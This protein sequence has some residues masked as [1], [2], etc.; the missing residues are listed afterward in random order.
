MIRNT[1]LFNKSQKNFVKIQKFFS[2]NYYSSQFWIDPF[3]SP[4]RMFNTIQTN[5]E[6][7]IDLSFL[8][9]PS[10][11]AM[12]K[13]MK[14]YGKKKELKTMIE[15]YKEMIKQKKEINEDTIEIL[16][17]YLGTKIKGNEKEFKKL[18]VDIPE[19]K[20]RNFSEK[21]NNQLIFIFHR[22]NDYEKIIEKFDEMVLKKQHKTERTYL[23]L[24]LDFIEKNDDTQL[25][26]LEEELLNEIN[27]LRLKNENENENISKQM[28]ELI[29]MLNK[30]IKYYC[31]GNS[32]KSVLE[33][34]NKMKEQQ[35][36]FTD[37][38]YRIKLV[39][40]SKMQQVKKVEEIY[41]ELLGR[42]IE[43]IKNNTEEV[44][45]RA[46]EG[47]F[48]IELITCF[49]NSFGQVGDFKKIDDILLY[50][51]YFQI[52]PNLTTLNTLI[53]FYSKSNLWE[54]IYSLLNSTISSPS[55]SPSSP[56][57][58]TSSLPSASA[59]E[60]LESQIKVDSP[61]TPLN[62]G[63]KEENDESEKNNKFHENYKKKEKINE[64]I[65]YL[66]EKKANKTNNN[67]QGI[68]VNK[69]ENE[70][71]VKLENEENLTIFEKIKSEK[72]GLEGWTK[73][74][75]NQGK[76]QI[77]DVDSE[78]EANISTITIL[79]DNLGKS[80]QFPLIVE[81]YNKLKQLKLNEIN[82][83]SQHKIEFDIM[84][85][86]TII[87]H[88]GKAKYF[89]KI[90]SLIE[91][92]I[93]FNILPNIHIYNSLIHSFSSF[94]AS[95]PFIP[96]HSLHAG[97]CND[98]FLKILLIFD[99][100]WE[101]F[102][103]FHPPPDH[104][105]FPPLIFLPLSSSS[106]SN[107]FPDSYTSSSSFSFSHTPS[108]FPDS[109]PLPVDSFLSTNPPIST[110]IPPLP[111]SKNQTQPKSTYHFTQHASEDVQNHWNNY[112]KAQGLFKQD[113]K[114]ELFSK[115]WKSLYF[116]EKEKEKKS[117]VQ[118]DISTFNTIIRILIKLN[119]FYLLNHILYKLSF[120]IHY[121]LYLSTSTLYYP[122]HSLPLSFQ[123]P[124]SPLSISSSSISSPSINGMFLFFLSSLLLF[125]PSPLS[126]PS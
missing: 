57:S 49:I 40:Y 100:L 101:N 63:I 120:S 42:T 83:E 28:D 23:I 37:E 126:L 104:L 5:Q 45:P 77:K 10:V 93:L 44:K 65:N 58:P 73:G 115:G 82:G 122:N 50:M 18:Y 54:N 99:K 4:K 95:L 30:M 19:N 114:S 33:I 3:R 2:N 66:L 109:Y 34:E 24:L 107:H 48:G 78:E 125:L 26:K 111:L 6:R 69:G 17:Y 8:E 14:F 91:D 7:E 119:K 43:K 12:T 84:F 98:Y 116:E 25:K 31:D 124:P 123:S 1:H 108:F 113:G 87:N 72:G 94:I 9:D 117:K 118:A 121:P 47:E 51:K 105:T 22:V 68:E 60:I 15:I 75:E 86:A 103:Y 41:H 62:L 81:F 56:S 64:I 52:K 89:Q 13:L 71:K 110:A 80:K 92:M 79:I 102:I 53:H 16:F 96:S 35:I 85:Y 88:Y 38:Y 20:K 27:H 29:K 70:K 59:K 32:I 112:G 76:I 39:Y 21:L 11:E 74:E 90:P 106:S 36:K 97:I 46:K 61:E 55:P 67:E